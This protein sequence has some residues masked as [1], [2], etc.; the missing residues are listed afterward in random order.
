MIQKL[1]FKILVFSLNNLGSIIFNFYCQKVIFQAQNGQKQ[2]K[3]QVAIL[4][5]FSSFGVFLLAEKLVKSFYSNL[6]EA[7]QTDPQ[8]FHCIIL[9]AGLILLVQLKFFS[10]TYLCMKICKNYPSLIHLLYSSFFPPLHIYFSLLVSLTFDTSH[11]IL[12]I[13]V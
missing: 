2:L 10:N 9:F 12:Q 5:N 7:L 6:V 13:S 4:N 1:G 3:G 11:L 8:V